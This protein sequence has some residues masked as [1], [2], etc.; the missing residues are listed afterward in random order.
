MPRYHLPKFEE[1][2]ERY[3]IEPRQF[4]KALEEYTDFATELV[5]E[6]RPQLDPFAFLK[7]S[8]ERSIVEAFFK[9]YFHQSPHLMLKQDDEED[10]DDDAF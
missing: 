10:L 4:Y 7:L 3:D 1:T 8:D 5:L 9:L 2:L 6:E